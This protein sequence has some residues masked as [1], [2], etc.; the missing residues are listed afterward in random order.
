MSD[1]D[2][3]SAGSDRIETGFEVGDWVTCQACGSSDVYARHQARGSHTPFDV[4]RFTCRAC[5]SER[6]YSSQ[7]TRIR[8][9]SPDTDQE[10]DPE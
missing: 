7:D 3:D 1:E 5:G 2:G 8:H 9:V 10:D 4:L 6:M